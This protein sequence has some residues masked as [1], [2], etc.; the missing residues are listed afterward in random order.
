MRNKEF[1]NNTRWRSRTVRRPDWVCKS[2]DILHHLHFTTDQYWIQLFVILKFWKYYTFRTRKLRNRSWKKNSRNV[3]CQQSL[4]KIRRKNLG[5][6]ILSFV[7]PCLGLLLR[8]IQFLVEICPATLTAIRWNIKLRPEHRVL[9]SNALMK[10]L[11]P[12]GAW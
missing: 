10:L 1:F 7:Y 9:Q 6:V 11:I 8:P 2:L 5:M 3:F 4:E 12:Y